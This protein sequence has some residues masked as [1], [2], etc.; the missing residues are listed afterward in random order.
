MVPVDAAGWSAA[1]AAIDHD[2]TAIRAAR[3]FDIAALLSGRARSLS[4]IFVSQSRR[5]RGPPKT[6][7]DVRNQEVIDE[8]FGGFR[9][10]DARARFASSR[11]VVRFLM[12]SVV[13]WVG[14]NLVR[15]APRET[16]SV[17][18]RDPTRH[19]EVPPRRNWTMIR[20]AASKFLI[21][22]AATL[23]SGAVAVNCGKKADHDDI[24]NVGLA[25]VLPGGGV[26][27]T[28]SYTISGSAIPM[29]IMGSIDVSAPGTT[30][31]TALVSGLPEGMY[32]VTMTAQST[33]MSQNCSGMAPFTVVRNQTAMANVILQCTRINTRGSVAINGRID[34]CPL[35]TSVSSNKLQGVV[36]GAPIMVGA[37]VSELDP[38]DTVTYNW[39]ANP[40]GIGT[41][42]AQ[43]SFTA[44]TCTAVGSTQLSLAVSDG[45]CGDNVMNAIPLNCVAGSGTGGAGGAGTGTGGVGGSPAGA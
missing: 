15:H 26:V 43:G 44:S 25:L 29:S 23:A 24:G 34:Q 36:N 4:Y 45:V 28:V 30:Q 7:V 11:I 10:S 8:D 33:D 42:G 35:I 1:C 22:T 2:V 13:T 41:I 31:A 27:N 18:V 37:V 3:D 5:L 16:G 32:T 20:K 6:G 39:T 14:S 17:F 12:W 21:L 38:G 19:L 40:T 9:Y